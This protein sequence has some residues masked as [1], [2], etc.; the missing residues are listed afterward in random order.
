MVFKKHNR[1]TEN[2][3]LLY[4]NQVLNFVKCFTYLGVNLSSN[5]NLHQTQKSLHEQSLKG[6]FPLNSVFDMVSLDISDKVRLFDSMVLPILCYGSEVWGFH[7]AVDIERVHTNFFKQLLSV[8]QQTS[9]VCM[10]GEPG[11]FPLYVYRQIRKIKY[12]FKLKG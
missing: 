1:R 5:G 4:N 2:V 6:L 12:W 8:K 11:R 10:Y 9:N 3:E 7:K